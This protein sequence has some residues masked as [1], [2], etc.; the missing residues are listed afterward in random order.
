MEITDTFNDQSKIESLINVNQA[1]SQIVL[2]KWDGVNYYASGSFESTNEEFAGD[3]S[4]IDLIVDQNIPSDGSIEYKV[5]VDNGNTWS[6]ITPVSTDGGFTVDT[7]NRKYFTTN[8]IG[9]SVK[10]RAIVYKSTS[11]NSS[12]TINSWSINVRYTTYA[13]AVLI[14]NT[15]PLNARGITNLVST[16]HDKQAERIRLA[17]GVGSAFAAEGTIQSTVRYSSN[18]VISVCLEVDETINPGTDIV[19]KIYTNG[20]SE[21]ENGQTI[22]PGLANNNEDWIEITNPGSQ[23]VI[24]AILSGDGLYTPLLNSWKL[25]IKEKIAGE[26]HLIKLVDEPWNLSALTNANYM[27][28]L[29]WEES[30]TDDVTYNVYRSTTPHFEPSEENRVA[31]NLAANSWS[32]YNLNYGQEFFYKVTAVKVINGHER[33]SLPSNED[34]AT[35]VSEGEMNKRLGLQDYWSYSG[36]NTG[37]GTGY[38]NVSNGNLSYI[39][40]DMVLPDPFLAVVMR[41]TYNSLADTTTPMGNGWDFS[42][43]TRLMRA[44]DVNGDETGMILKDGDGSFHIFAKNLDGTYQ[45]AKGTLMVLTHDTTLGEYQIRRKDNIVYHFDDQ[46]MRLD[47]FSDNNGNTLS[48]DYDNRGNLKTVENTVGD[49]VELDY[50]VVNEN[51]QIVQITDPDYSYIN[52]HPDM[53]KSITWTED[54]AINPVTI[55]YTYEYDDDFNKLTRAYTVIENS[56]EYEEV[57]SYDPQTGELLTITDPEGNSTG[58]SYDANDRIDIITDAC[59][60]A[61]TYDFDYLS[62]NTSIT[63]KYDTSVSY[64]FDS[65]G[66]VTSTTNPM[67]HTINYSYNNDLQVTSASYLN[68]VDG[69]STPET[70]STAMSYVDGNL[71]TITAADGTVTTYSNYN[72]FN[73]PLSM[74]VSKSGETTRTTTYTYDTATGNLLTAT[75][76]EGKTTTNVYE[77]VN[78]DPGYLTWVINDFDGKTHYIYNSKGQVEQVD[79]YIGSSYEYTSVSYAY[80]YNEDGFF[81]RVIATD[82]LGIQTKTYYDRLGRTVKVVSDDD[83]DKY[84]TASYDLV[85]NVRFSVDRMGY[86]TEFQYDE[87][88]RL[89]HI[90]YPDDTISSIEYLKWN[91][92]DNTNT[93]Y[94]SNGEDADKVIRTAEVGGVQNIEYYDIAG[95]L[96]KTAISNGTGEIVTAHYEYDLIG[97]CT[98]VTDNAGRVSEAHYNELNQTTQSIVDPTGENIQSVFTYDM[99]GNNSSTTNGEGYT[100][101]YSYD[102][103]SRLD[104]VSQTINVGTQDE[105]DLI[106][107]YAYDIEDGGY[108]KNRVT[109]ANGHVNEAWFDALGRKLF[110]YNIGDAGDSIT[111]QTGYEYYDNGQ[112]YLV[113]RNDGTKEKYT[114]TNLC[115]LKRIDYYE[116]S[117]SIENDSDDYVYYE[118]NDNGQ[119]LLSSVYHDSDEVSTAYTY[120]SKGRTDTIT[121]GDLNNGGLIVDYDYDASDRV[122]QISY[123]KDDTQRKLGYVYDTFGRIWEITLALGTETPELVREY[124]YK[125]NGDLDSIKNYRNFENDGTEYI[126]LVYELNNAGMTSKITYTDHAATQ[127]KKEEYILSY[128]KRGYITDET[129]YTNYDSAQTVIK[130]FDYDEIG[131]LET[132]TVGSQ[133]TSYTYDSVGN[134]ESMDDETDL[135]EYTY[136]QF[137]QLE[138]VTKN[139]SDYLSY[140]FDDLGNQVEEVLVGYLSV[141][142]GETT[143]TYDRETSFDYNL[144]NRLSDLEIT[145]PEADELGNVTYDVVSTTNTYNAAGQRVKRLED[146]YTTKYYYSGSALL[147]TTNIDNHLLTENILDL[148]GNIVASLRFDAQNP[149]DPFEG[150]FYFYNY[151]C[152]GSTTSIIAPDGTLTTGYSYD[153]FGNQEL[154]GSSSFLNEVTFTGSVSDISSGLQYMNARFYNPTT[155]RFLSQDTYSGNA[156]DPWTQHLYAYCGNNPVNMIDPTGHSAEGI[157]G[158]DLMSQIQGAIQQIGIS[159]SNQK[160]KFLS[161]KEGCWADGGAP[162]ADIAMGVGALA[163]LGYCVYEGVNTYSQ[164]LTIDKPA[165]VENDDAKAKEAEIDI[166]SEMKQGNDIHH[167]VAQK[168]PYAVPAR[169]VLESVNIDP[170]TNPLNLV[171]VPRTFHRIM[172]T[173]GYYDYV[174]IRLSPYEG[175][176]DGVIMTLASLAAEIEFRAYTGNRW[177]GKMDFL[178]FD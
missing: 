153:E 176:L 166:V 155:G 125:T 52:Y 173:K 105:E 53:L 163:L 86:E 174:N 103:D 62:N 25:V 147:F 135:F 111:I 78:G 156:Y 138:T 168:S 70:V 47:G 149:D 66:Q 108:I 27:T 165:A 131:R 142:V 123:A 139:S 89:E 113:T 146:G 16:E 23:I 58:I 12:P 77:T 94:G 127:V 69:G 121:E 15:F 124:S 152:R 81:Q 65:N 63:S 114:Y 95:R 18:D 143:T 38:V 90:I 100:T 4:Y 172:H 32:D 83:D 171:P 110:D 64:I 5:S 43:N 88:N 101:T 51:Q 60:D 57:F 151:D 14:D 170:K 50:Y 107:S 169:L 33:E 136:N 116:S 73:K 109:D 97:N 104:S 82:A 161:L 44:Y 134:R 68:Y 130:S 92:D 55:S 17:Y 137:N 21:G 22:E 122:T 115:Q 93:G 48:F 37:S 42:L 79:A 11:Q 99:M 41:R 40:T 75:D 140:S 71:E 30:D 162:F 54:T 144:M 10:L 87:L 178:V 2:D 177:P 3:I 46:S 159:I 157:F 1:S 164:T 145:T 6:N 19:Y 98:K 129:I 59:E 80:D 45:S 102:L 9:D 84:E 34:N 91:C 67:G 74:S 26:P 20:K 132:A 141:T 8:P 112:I 76:P 133:T 85:G 118:Y 7:N 167:I 56:V 39:T 175:D 154:T 96:V 128:D 106:T 126:E 150:D 61:N 29:R 117:E 35:I 36:F 119:L 160:D 24:E 158:S 28:L 148:G 72:S 49:I 13:N 31:E 120:D